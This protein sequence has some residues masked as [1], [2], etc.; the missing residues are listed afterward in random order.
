M[1][2]ENLFAVL[3]KKPLGV[4][5][6]VLAGV[7]LLLAFGYWQFFYSGLQEEKGGALSRKKAISKKLDELREDAK[8]L[9]GLRRE[10]AERKLKIEKGLLK[11]P[12]KS[13]LPA[14]LKQ[15]QNQAGAAGVRL[16]SYSQMKEGAV[17]DFIK[18]P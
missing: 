13:E 1:A 6:G 17:E 3:A 8:T 9:E 18:V 14:F 4:Q 11:L 5:L 12:A 15:L 10:R 16:R 7:L 2:K